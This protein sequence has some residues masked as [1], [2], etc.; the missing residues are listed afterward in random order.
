MIELKGKYTTAQIMIDEVEQE[1]ISQIDR[2]INHPVFSN[3]VVI[4]P[5]THAGKGSVIGFTM[6]L[7]NYVIPNVI[8]V[9]I[10]CGMI[11][12]SIGNTLN[13]HP[14]KIDRKI[15][16][17]IPMSTSIHASN[18]SE[19]I[20]Y[21]AV[22]KMQA[23]FIHNY[24][25][26]FATN[27]QM[28]EYNEQWLNA[29]IK[30]IGIDHHRFYNSL[31]TL[32]GGNHFIE[33]GISNNNYYL[34]IHSGSRN[35]GL[36]IAEYWQKIALGNMEVTDISDEVIKKKKKKI[37][38]AH[39]ELACLDAENMMHYLRDMIFAQ[40]YAHLNRKSM[41]NLIAHRLKINI[42]GETIESTHN[43]IDFKDMIIRKGAI[44]A[45]TAEK[46][47]IPF[48]MRD[49]ILICEGKSNHNWNFSAPH[50]AGRLMSRSKAKQVINLE[51]YKQSMK[52]IFSSCVNK[53]TIDESPMVY[54]NPKI[55]EKLIEPTADILFRIKPVL[56]IK[57]TE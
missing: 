17:V 32:G 44:R 27:Y 35:F 24:N 46:M 50:G 19:K 4:M 57:A 34:T 39:K 37:S 45:Y 16:S 42:E 40:Y 38:G 13:E 30:Q 28:H 20:D 54:K 29:K 3:Q 10:G 47:I 21:D 11:T 2:M 12:S 36:K 53:N 33:I 25:Q 41:L 43:Y 48:N 55:I 1:C 52:G 9:D 18:Q 31:G 56:N 15:Q 23:M 26:M 6:P 49:G 5:D 7:S 51:D 22:N 8:G 14:E